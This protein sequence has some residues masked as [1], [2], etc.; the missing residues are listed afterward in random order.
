MKNRTHKCK[1]FQAANQVLMNT[2]K[3]PHAEEQSQLITKLL[4]YAPDR[5]KLR[6][7]I[8]AMCIEFDKKIKQY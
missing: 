3:T 2:I 1:T 7:I 8:R 6:K 5:G 4:T